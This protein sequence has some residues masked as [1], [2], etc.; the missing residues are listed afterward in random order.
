MDTKDK[1]P[2]EFQ[3][4]GTGAENSPVPPMDNED[5]HKTEA[6]DAME[7]TAILSEDDFD[8]GKTQLIEN[9]FAKPA[10]LIVV[11]GPDQGRE[12][13]LMKEEMTIGRALDCDGV[14][15]DPTVSRHHCQ[16]LN[17]GPVFVL[18][19]LGSGN[20]T[21]LNGT[22]TD[23][24]PLAEGARIELGQ[25]V[26]AF[27]TKLSG[28]PASGHTAQMPRDGHDSRT[29]ATE[30]PKEML[31]THVEQP[32]KE[33]GSPW[34]KI[35]L[36]L[37]V[38]VLLGGIGV[39][40]LQYGFGV[41]IIGNK[42]QPPVVT[43]VSPHKKALKAYN[44]GI[45]LMGKK[46][47]DRAMAKFQ[48]ALDLDPELTGASKR[49]E[50]C[51]KEK[52]TLMTIRKAD[53]LAR[54]GKVDDAKH[55]LQAVTRESVYFP[56]ARSKLILLN[57]KEAAI[58][59]NKVKAMV[60]AG[61]VKEA[62]KIF[63]GLL[64]K[65]PSNTEVLALADLF[66]DKQTKKQR[67]ASTTHRSKRVAKRRG[68]KATVDMTAVLSMYATGNFDDAVAELRDYVKAVRSPREKADKTKLADDIQSFA[69]VYNAGKKALRGGDYTVAIRNLSQARRLD[70]GISGKYQ[71]ELKK[72]LAS[73]YRER[74][75]QYVMQKQ[76][77][78]AARDARAALA[79]NPGDRAALMVLNK[80]QQVAKG[81]YDSAMAD[82]KAGNTAG[83]KAKLQKV[84]QLVTRDSDL[85]KQASTRYQQIR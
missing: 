6:F 31:R 61:D 35:A 70:R 38:L 22:R 68:T 80:C 54:Q 28:V 32:G 78:Q 8:E 25:T 10:R 21:K 64:D 29:L 85:Y 23:E 13:P 34:G 45:A 55:L 37:G 65:Y 33:S 27:S 81:F 24:A 82:M 36:I 52:H 77:V 41:Q 73:A 26:M 49:L 30:M 11:F 74:A 4:Q 58:A 76:Y 57:D 71:V 72:M 40:V 5:R 83:A 50:I 3:D 63:L 18:K 47:W 84:M 69:A 20:G 59:V 14:L 44:K 2:V 56:Q 46:E 51:Q 79:L 67:V 9:P 16:I 62:K 12:F 66:K 42:E 15:N 48:A 43:E 53:Q 75:A 7:K 1:T 60:A 39:A 17:R 19:D